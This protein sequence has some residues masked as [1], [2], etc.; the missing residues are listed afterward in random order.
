MKMNTSS[1]FLYSISLKL[2]FWLWL[3]VIISV[4]VSHFITLQ[5]TNQTNITPPNKNNIQ[6]LQNHVKNITQEQTSLIKEQKKFRTAYR[7]HLI[8][9]NVETNHITLPQDKNWGKLRDYLQEN[10]F[11]N[12]A[13]FEFPYTKITGPVNAKINNHTFQVFI[14]TDSS[15]QRFNYFINQFPLW[16][17]IFFVLIISFVLCWL[18]AKNIN[19]PLIAIQNAAIAFGKGNL[20]VRLGDEVHRNDELGQVARSFNIM[21]KKLENHIHAHQRLLGDVSHE[22]RSPLTRLQLAI[23]LVEKYHDKPEEQKKHINRCEHEVMQLDA[24]LAD[25]LTLS[26]L[27]N[28]TETVHLSSVNF[29]QLVSMVVDDYQ[30]LANNKQV[31][32][33]LNEQQAIVTQLDEKLMIS[34]VSNIINNAVKYAPENSKINVLIEQKNNHVYLSVEDSGPGVPSETLKKLFKPF[35]R[36][37]DARDR[38][39]GGTG[40]GLAIAQQAI[41]L[42]EGKIYATNNNDAG[43]TVHINFPIK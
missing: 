37:T 23:G 30:Y 35:Y 28:A 13:S 20:S 7:F 5:L 31:T 22:L 32:I 12:A 4:L 14:A 3:V 33:H 21:A 2:F 36:V 34:V 18:L 15:Y 10:R 17:R 39:S 41:A 1:K 6:L 40:L 8:F 43:L 27:E 16:L 26:R 11:V 38:K 19:K 29:T 24:M 42:H 25:V 9:K